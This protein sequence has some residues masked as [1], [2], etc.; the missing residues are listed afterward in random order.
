MYDWLLF[1]AEIWGR[2]FSSLFFF[3]CGE[4]GGRLSFF[5]EGKSKKILS[6][7]LSDTNQGGKLPAQNDKIFKQHLVSAMEGMKKREGLI[8]KFSESPPDEEYWF[9]IR[10]QDIGHV[11][12]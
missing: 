5:E 6:I 2:F 4:V 1:T 12:L 8:I 3:S 9:N 10:Y 11:L 7:S